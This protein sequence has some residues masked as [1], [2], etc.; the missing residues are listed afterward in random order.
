MYLCGECNSRRGDNDDFIRG[1]DEICDR[2][3]IEFNQNKYGEI[4]LDF[5]INVNRSKQFVK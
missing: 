3:V 2:E 5:L 1:I 4:L